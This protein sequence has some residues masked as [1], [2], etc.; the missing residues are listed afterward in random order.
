MTTITRPPA[1]A[2]T[3]TARP[4]T[5]PPRPWRLGRRA[6]RVALTAHILAAVGWFGIAVAIAVGAILAGVTGD[7]SL[8][9]SLYRILGLAPWLSIPAGLVA[10]ATGVVLSV[11]TRWGLLTHWWVVAKIAGAV[12]VVVTDGLIVARAAN[13]ALA[14]GSAPPPL[15]GGTIA[16]VVL[17]GVAVVLSVFKPW[18]RTPWSASRTP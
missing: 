1:A 9:S 8:A 4:A 17:L 13:E 3:A 10:I 15:Y 16:H 14:A 11:G 2:R 18:G 7:Q 6:H 5:G 12:A